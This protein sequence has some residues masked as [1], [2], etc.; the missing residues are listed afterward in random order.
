MAD[1]DAKS[2]GR[3]ARRR[4]AH[5]NFLGNFNDPAGEAANGLASG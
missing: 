4:S 5:A 1:S 3:T 2:N